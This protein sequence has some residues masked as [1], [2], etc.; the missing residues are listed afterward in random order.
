MERGRMPA[1]VL[2]ALLAL[3]LLALPARADYYYTNN[4]GLNNN[5]GNAD[6]G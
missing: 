3:A 6:W 5:A 2:L 4:N 1:V